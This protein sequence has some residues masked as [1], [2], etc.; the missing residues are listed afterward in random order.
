MYRVTVSSQFR[1]IAELEATQRT[2]PPITH[3][4]IVLSQLVSQTSP[5]LGRFFSQILQ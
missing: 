2:V 1:L 5:V 4:L 3:L